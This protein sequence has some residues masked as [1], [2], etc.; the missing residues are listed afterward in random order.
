METLLNLG[1]IIKKKRLSLNKRMDDVAS[2]ANITRATLWTIEK[3]NNNYSIESLMRVL[4]VLDLSLCVNVSIK[5]E[6]RHRASRIN[7]VLSKKKNRFVIL[8]VQQYSATIN[9]SSASTYKRMLDKSVIVELINDYEDLHGM[10]QIWLNDYI[11]TL[12]T[13]EPLNIL[14]QSSSHIA[15]KTILITKVSELIAEKYRISIDK[16]RNLLY[17]SP[18]IDLIDDDETGLYGDSPLYVFSLF[19]AEHKK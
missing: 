4:N 3:G 12:M 18:V 14:E 6:R 17:E 7:S 10:S 13:G 2:E 16:A 8:C 11:N 5:N 9:E 1:S 19:E 15:A